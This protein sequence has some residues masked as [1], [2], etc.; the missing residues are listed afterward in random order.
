ML[1]KILFHYPI[2]DRRYDFDKEELSSIELAG[3]TAEKVNEVVEIVNTVD[4]RIKGKED[5]ENITVNRKLSSLGNFSGTLLGRT[6]LSIFTDINNALSLS[7]TIIDMVNDRE[8]IG[9]IYDGGSFLE[10]D[11]P[12]ITIEG[13]LF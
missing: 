5:S 12:T 1:G 9:T 10:T 6:I 8:S 2:H 3:R 11:P 13:G 4:G 7:Q